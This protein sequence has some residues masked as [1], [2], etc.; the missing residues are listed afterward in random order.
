ML[1]FYMIIIP[2]ATAGLPG[3]S[4]FNI[5]VTHQQLKYRLIHEDVYAVVLGGS[6]ILGLVS[7]IVLFRF[8][9][10]KK[11]TTIFFSLGLTRTRLFWNRCIVGLCMLFF[12]IAVPMLVSLEL[13]VKALGVYE[14]LIRDAFYVTAGLFLTACIGYFVMIIVCAAAGTTAESIVFWCGIMGAPYGIC[15][16][17]NALLKTLFWGNA[18]GAVTYSETATVRPDLTTQFAW[19][20][21]FS[22][23]YEE[24]QSHGQFM[25]P[26]E[27][28]VPPAVE[29]KL[30]HGWS[31][32]A[33]IL[34]I[35]GLMLLRCRK[36]ESAGIAGSN[37][38]LSEW[39]ILF[40]SFLVFVLIFAFLYDFSEA[41]AI[42]LSI[43]GVAVIHLFW[44]HSLFAYDLTVRHTI[45]SL[46]G[47]VAVCLVLSGCFASGGLRSVEHYFHRGDIVSVDVS[48]VGSPSCLYEGADGSS[49]GRGYYVTSQITFEK[50]SSIARVQE[51]QT[52]FAK[53]G[54][55]NLKTNE[56]DF[57]QTVVPYDITFSYT[58]AS[59][60]SHT[61]YY[62]R[63]TM[64]QLEEILSLE[65]TSEMTEGR[66]ALFA[67]EAGDGNETIWASEA[68]QQGAVYLTDRF[69]SRTY[70]LTLDEDQRAGL[71]AAIRKDQQKTDSQTRYFPGTDTKAVLMFSGN[72]EYDSEY[73]SYNLDNAFLYLTEQDTNTLEW[74]ENNQLLSLVEGDVEIESITLQKFDPYIGI[75]GMKYPTSM[76]F[77]SYRAYSLDEFLI[78]KDF[79]AKNTITDASKINQILP[80]LRNG[81]F[82]SDGGYLAAVKTKGMD[83]YIYMF[84]PAKY[85]PGF[86]K[87]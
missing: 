15:Y 69:C 33:I 79:G 37:H 55:Q 64:E 59:G 39:M 45:F 28:A 22:F 21:P 26:L 5:E 9:Q 80:G 77:M 29:P 53:T 31:C 48:Y 84:L 87:G 20:N 51:I 46:A 40:T 60:K 30:I 73:F 83:G 57:S 72:G 47:G 14:G 12:G 41:T 76:Y 34:M 43:A 63:A 3:D 70:E 32:A 85:V 71:L 24:L 65:D 67:G 10:D 56:E 17:V 16:G 62:D 78:Q 25:R 36:A 18:W 52:G 81:Y 44:R 66:D 19:L 54:K 1:A 42:V 61:W 82:M 27:S 74:L 8:L 11:E 2:F 86:V 38:W 58:D 7:G 4:I 6:S 23:F 49:T 75:N 68:Y 13:N 35:A 50:K